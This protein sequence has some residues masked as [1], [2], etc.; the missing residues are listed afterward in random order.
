VESIVSFGYWVHRRRKALDLTQTMLAGQVGCSPVTIRKIE[1]DERRPSRQIAE[2]LADHLLIPEAD[3]DRF[4]RMARGEFIAAMPSPLEAVPSA[5]FWQERDASPARADTFFAA[6]EAELAQLDAYLDLALAGQPA[7][8]PPEG[9]VPVGPGGRVAFV[10]GGAGRGKTALVQEFTRRAQE[11]QAGLVVAGGNCNAYSGVG[12]PYLP[13]REILGLLTGDV[14][15]RWVAGSMSRLQAQRLWDLT[16][17]AVQA[18]VDSGPD[19][20]DTFIPG[21][22]LVS[23]AMAA[24][25]GGAGWLARLEA[26]AAG[27][28]AGQGPKDL[29]QSDL[30]EQYV[31]V[32]LA[33]ARE[34]PLL[35]VLDDLQW[36][37]AGSIG[38]LFH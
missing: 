22:G 36:A 25:P 3:R 16:P 32:L 8:R 6:R 19:L 30:F 20:V 14:Q 12:D 24:A 1:G 10:L 26:L 9:G 5:I 21:P 2:L 27:Q 17:A 4:L 38:L 18:L 33:L 28:A 13:F 23:R 7:R 34:R 11:R 31:K 37:D 29:K 35:L 15:A